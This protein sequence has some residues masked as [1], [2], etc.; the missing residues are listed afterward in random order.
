MFDE[1]VQGISRGRILAAHESAIQNAGVSAP[2]VAE[3]KF[4]PR[5]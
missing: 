1:P 4:Y 2:D 3:T 5:N